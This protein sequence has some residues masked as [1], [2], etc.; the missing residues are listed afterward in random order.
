MENRRDPLVVEVSPAMTHASH[1]GS[2]HAATAHMSRSHYRHL[3]IMTG[4]SFVAM[5]GLMYAMVDALTNVHHNLNQFYMA[6]LMTGAMVL[7]EIV[8]MRGMYHDKRLN[9][10]IVAAAVV[11]LIVSW[12]FIRQQTAIGDRQ[13]LRSM[14]PHHAGAILMCQQASLRDAE[15]LRLCQ[16]IISGQQAEI[17]QMKAKLNE[18]RQ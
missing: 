15:N 11:A 4:L 10:V 5:Y 7:I 18:P 12:L 2:S 6:G 9:M 13:F 1:S 17:D 14:I 3:L 16:N 8:V